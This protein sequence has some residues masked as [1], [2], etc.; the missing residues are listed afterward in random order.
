[1]LHKSNFSIEA[2]V[3]NQSGAMETRD[4]SKNGASLK[5]QMS[6]VKMFSLLL[7][8]SFLF[9]C[10]KT[11]E[12]NLDTSNNNTTTVVEPIIFFDAEGGTTDVKIECDIELIVKQV[13]DWITVTKTGNTGEQIFH[14]IASK[15]ELNEIR[16]SHVICM[17]QET[18]AHSIESTTAVIS[19]VQYGQDSDE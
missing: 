13:P 1:M 17:G 18:T 3:A 2:A 19:V 16:T 4:H 15:N 7:I 6:K 12:I 11:D 8:V 9:G 5:S 10:T 14:L